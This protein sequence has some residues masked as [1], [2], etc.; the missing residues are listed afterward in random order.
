M[1]KTAISI[2]ALTLAIASVSTGAL[3]RQ[4][5][6]QT[7][8][9]LNQQQLQGVSIQSA[10]P[11]QNPT[12]DQQYSEPAPMPQADTTTSVI[13]AAPA[14]TSLEAYGQP[15]TNPQST[16]TPSVDQPYVAVVPAPNGE[17]DAPTGQ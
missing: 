12:A 15:D 11:A 10:Q 6:N 4:T 17:T 1:T 5:A 14:H 3:A 9:Q 16:G 13:V 7:T 2:A 8:A